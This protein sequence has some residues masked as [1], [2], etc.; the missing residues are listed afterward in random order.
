MGEKKNKKYCYEQN[1]SLHKNVKGQLQHKLEIHTESHSRPTKKERFI[2][3]EKIRKKK[4]QN[5]RTT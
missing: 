2:Q 5:R 3:I 4:S 1:P